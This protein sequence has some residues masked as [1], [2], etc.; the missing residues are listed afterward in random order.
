M[1]HTLIDNLKYKKFGVSIWKS[2]FKFGGGNEELLYSNKNFTFDQFRKYQWYFEYLAA[3]FKIK[4]PKSFIRI[5]TFD[6]IK[7]PK[8]EQLLID[9]KNR[10]KSLRSVITKTKNG[11]RKH[12]EGGYELFPEENILLQKA[13]AKLDEK[14][15]HLKLELLKKDILISKMNNMI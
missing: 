10:I 9:S 6:Y 4:H 14:Q 11:I 5:D 8:N 15:E 7:L 1:K 13:V 3:T 12:L 2:K